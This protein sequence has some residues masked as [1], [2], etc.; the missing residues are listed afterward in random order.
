MSDLRAVGLRGAVEIRHLAYAMRSGVADVRGD[1]Q[2][3]F[4][5]AIAAANASIDSK[6]GYRIDAAGLRR[7]F[8][9]IG[10]DPRTIFLEAIWDANADIVANGGVSA[11]P[12]VVFAS[13]PRKIVLRPRRSTRL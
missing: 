1:A 10:E 12:A 8:H 5:S 2:A 11:P 6:T 13:G 7:A 4:L 9:E 3:A